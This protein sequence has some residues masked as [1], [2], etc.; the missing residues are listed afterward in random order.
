MTPQILHWK[1]CLHYFD[2]TDG[3]YVTVK[4]RFTRL[5]TEVETNK[6]K[7]RINKLTF[8]NVNVWVETYLFSIC[9][10][11]FGNT[12]RF[13]ATF[14]LMHFYAVPLNFASLCLCLHSIPWSTIIVKDRVKLKKQSILNYDYRVVVLAISIKAKVINYNHSILYFHWQSVWPDKNHQMSIKVTQIGFH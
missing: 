11:D 9:T 1:L 14:T 8:R 13:K 12:K 2:F 3:H 6:F 10:Y 4:K 7:F 5:T